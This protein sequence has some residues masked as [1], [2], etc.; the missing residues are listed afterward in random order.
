M[1]WAERYLSQASG[2][3]TDAG[4]SAAGFTLLGMIGTHLHTITLSVYLVY[5]SFPGNGA[6]T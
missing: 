5:E 2:N 6:T 1:K 3:I 4:E